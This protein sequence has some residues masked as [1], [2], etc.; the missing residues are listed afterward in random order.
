MVSVVIEVNINWYE[1]S[2]TDDSNEPRDQ[3]GQYS[4]PANADQEGE[5]VDAS[6]FTAPTYV[7]D[8]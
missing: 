5:K 6:P 8:C 3:I 7:R 2:I 4:N 1:P